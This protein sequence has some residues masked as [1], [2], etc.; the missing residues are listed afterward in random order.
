MAAEP[1]R[2]AAAPAVPRDDGAAD[3]AQRGGSPVPAGAAAGASASGS[4]PPSNGA[5]G[6]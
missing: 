5:P 1:R 2:P 4:R 6:K 3:L